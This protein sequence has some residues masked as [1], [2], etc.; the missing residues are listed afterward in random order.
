MASGKISYNATQHRE[1]EAE[2]D[3]IGDNF[4]ALITDLDSLKSSVSDNLKGKA[5]TSLSTEL[6]SLVS[7]LQT[8]KES[9][10]TVKTNA[11]KVEKLIKKADENASKT[12][13]G[14][15]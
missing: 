7:K 3:K 14:D 9:W 11:K 10:S 15:S 6:S 1:L 2:L 4:D 5:A 12:I 8:E 13:E